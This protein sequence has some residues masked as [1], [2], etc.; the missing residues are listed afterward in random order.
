MAATLAA[1]RKLGSAHSRV[2]LHYIEHRRVHARTLL[3]AIASRVGEPMRFGWEPSA[4]PDWLATRGFRLLSD[5]G[6]EALARRY[7]PARWSARF[8]GAG[9][10]IALAQPG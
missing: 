1:V 9:G 2:V 6:D 5:E 3:H 4:L 10:H 8:E 7:F